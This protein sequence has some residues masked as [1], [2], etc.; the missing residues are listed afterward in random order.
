VENVRLSINYQLI[1]SSNVTTS[2]PTPL[3]TELARETMSCME[4]WGGNRSTWSH[5]VVPGLDLWVHSQP[6][7]TQ[8]CGGDVYYLSSCASGRI[9]RMFLGDVSG[10]GAEA[11]PTA[12]KF[13]DILRKN[14][15]YINQSRVVKSLNEQFGDAATTGRFATAFISTYFA[16][17]QELS[18]CVAGH[19]PALIYRASKK[20][21]EA[22]EANGSASGNIPIGVL[23]GQEFSATKW[24]LQTGDI[25]MAYSDAL[26]ESCAA[27]GTMLSLAGLLQVANSLKTSDPGE[28]VQGLLESI[29]KLNPANLASDDTTIVV[30]RVNQHG[31]PLK[32]NLLA[33]FRFLKG[34]LKR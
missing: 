30:A 31:V 29:R 20:Q 9:T 17:T 23:G 1:G 4:V 33:P 26:Y 32:D 22:L 11:A 7:G 16:P 21:W 27:D 5:F 25:V 24:K 3:I 28:F 6:F 34:L 2:S 12:A 8:D 13:R 18:V 19:P 15:N 14:V 10:H